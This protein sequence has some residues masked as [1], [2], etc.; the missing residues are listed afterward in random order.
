MYSGAQI[1]LANPVITWSIFPVS[2]L[3]ILQLLTT[4]S[5]S[6][7]LVANGAQSCGESVR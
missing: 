5:G 1:C 6:I 2:G 3:P 7:D 4:S